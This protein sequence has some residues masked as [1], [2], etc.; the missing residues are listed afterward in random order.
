MDIHGG[1]SDPVVLQSQGQRGLVHQAAPG[2][3][4]QEGARPHLLDGVLVDEMVVV[5]VEGAVQGHAVGLEYQGCPPPCRG[6]FRGVVTPA[7]LC[8]KE[9]SLGKLWTNE[10]RAST[11]LDQ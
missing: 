9:A 11:L 10:S 8:H 6:L 3:V 5:F 4:D 2:G 1:R 7:V